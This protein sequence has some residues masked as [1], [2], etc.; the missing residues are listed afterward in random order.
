VNDQSIQSSGRRIAAATRLLWS[1]LVAIL[2]LQLLPGILSAAPT[3]IFD[4]EWTP[5][6]RG[7][8]TPVVVPASRPA[9]PNASALPPQTQVPPSPRTA[10]PAPVAA[11]AR[12]ALPVKVDQ[13]K[14]RKLLR[15]VY[16]AQLADRSVA[17]RKK[18]AA[19]LLAEARKAADNPV[20]QYVLLG[21]AI[22][23]GR[24]ASSIGICMQAADAMAAT[25]EVDSL[26]VKADAVLRTNLA[27]AGSQSAV[28]ENV[29]AALELVDELMAVEEFATSVRLCAAIQPAAS[30]SPALRAST[31]QKA[32]DAA[33][34]RSAQEKLPPHL[35]R[36]RT[37]PLDPGACLAVGGYLCFMKGDWRAGLPLLAE[38]SNPL[39]KSAA[40]AEIAMLRNGNGHVEA[41]DA[42]WAAA[43]K[44]PAGPALTAMRQRIV[45]AYRQ[46][47][48]SREVSGLSRTR[49]EK[50]LE[51]LATLA[52]GTAGTQGNARAATAQEPNRAGGVLLIRSAANPAEE[53][54]ATS[55]FG[56]RARLFQ[57]RKD[58]YGILN[59]P[60]GLSTLSTVVFGTNQ[61]GGAEAA[62]LSDSLLEKLKQFVS[63]GGDVV[64]YP[65]NHATNMP[66]V[67]RTFG[68]RTG[69]SPGK[70]SK[71]V[72]EALK[73]KAVAAGLTDEVMQELRFQ[74]RYENLPE[75]TRVLVSSA[76]DSIPVAVLVP[77]GRGRLILLGVSGNTQSNEVKMNSAILELVYRSAP[78]TP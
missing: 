44:E 11:A 15:E 64:F 65:Q 5:P 52:K 48:T 37:S 60:K 40:A 27:L 20:D 77:Y 51:S 18:L 22:E 16:A 31:Q 24:E 55:L 10:S 69:G 30:A 72:D 53:Q 75:G 54:D 25:F 23:A 57:S 49:I 34:A 21:G 33:M 74:N 66:L 67:E 12:R 1:S 59:D 36:L 14:S 50:R 47:L 39:L 35:E 17:A 8:P 71:I 62:L 26:A 28:V 2:V 9:A 3:S 58:A 70:G 13:E 38:G 63:A 43:E 29:E 78:A 46:A 61:W 6:K 76:K 32:R 41:G 45:S 42:W 4:D 68:V 7:N 56:K 19:E 73:A